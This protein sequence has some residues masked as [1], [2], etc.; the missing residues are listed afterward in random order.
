MAKSV[1]SF[2]ASPSKVAH[3]L[4]WKKA[5]GAILSLRIVKDRID[6]AVSSHPS[7]Q[8]PAQPLPSIPLK[9]ET[10]NNRKVLKAEVAQELQDIVRNFNVCGMVVNWPVQKEGRCGASCGRVLH[11]LDQIAINSSRPVC[12]FDSNHYEPPEDDWGRAKVY[13]E[14]SDKTLHVASEEQ[15]KDSSG[16]L[17]ADIWNNF[18]QEHWPELYRQQQQNTS[19]APAGKKNFVSGLFPARLVREEE[20]ALYATA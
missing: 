9:M 7:F 6:L 19:Y 20:E 5:S 8:E 18:C 14:T 11:T 10:S 1:T 17:A 12:L 13:S 4:D 15:Y 2:L 16:I 3:A